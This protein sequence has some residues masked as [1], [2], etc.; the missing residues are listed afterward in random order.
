M[1]ISL[2]FLGWTQMGGTYAFLPL[3]HPQVDLSIIRGPKH[4]IVLCFFL[5][6]PKAKLLGLG[7][8]LGNRGRLISSWGLTHTAPPGGCVCLLCGVPAT[9]CLMT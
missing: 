6:A 7:V 3:F 1:L 5:N 9:Y 8:G 2:F 4:R